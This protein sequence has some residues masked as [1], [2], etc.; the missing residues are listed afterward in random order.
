MIKS[1][2]NVRFHSQCSWPSDVCQG[3]AAD[4]PQRS[5]VPPHRNTHSASVVITSLSPCTAMNFTWLQN[6]SDELTRIEWGS[7]V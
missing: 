1:K 4:S 7:N 3:I 2:K 6:S 5:A